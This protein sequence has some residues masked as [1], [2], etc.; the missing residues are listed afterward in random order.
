MV[1]YAAPYLHLAMGAYSAGGALPAQQRGPPP[2]PGQRDED[3]YGKQEDGNYV[4]RAQ[5]GVVW[6]LCGVVGALLMGG[7]AMCGCCACLL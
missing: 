3:H 6:A 1:Q 2:R 5:P 7:L 4:L